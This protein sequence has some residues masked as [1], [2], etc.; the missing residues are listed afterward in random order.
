MTGIRCFA[1]ALVL[2]LPST[3]A[4]DPVILTANLGAHWGAGGGSM[5]QGATGELFLEMLR[6][7]D[8]TTVEFLSTPVTAASVGQTFR[9][10]AASGSAFAEARS[11]LT[12][13]LR[14]FLNAGVRF[15]DD[16]WVES[17]YF[18]T[19]LVQRPFDSPNPDLR[20][21]AISGVA[22]TLTRYL[23]TETRTTRELDWQATLAVEGT[24]ATPEPGS[25]LLL[26]SGLAGLAAR[27]RR[28]VA[29]RT[30]D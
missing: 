9:T 12:N 14:D 28:T 19:D 18:E 10:D 23:L 21:F 20:G 15:P 16:A 11:I 3:A 7:S 13:G 22:V 26:A 8:L 2:V 6:V 30:L 4:A 24:A 5:V 25:L 29:S 27:R 17:D 1:V